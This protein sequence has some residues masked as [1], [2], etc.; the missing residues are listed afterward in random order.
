MYLKQKYVKTKIGNIIVFSEMMQH[1]EFKK[2]EPTSAGF[3]SIGIGNDGNPSCTCYGESV[4]LKLKSHEEDTIK[5]M[6]QILGSTE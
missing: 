3:I 1:S 2:F 6:N 5:A 4:S